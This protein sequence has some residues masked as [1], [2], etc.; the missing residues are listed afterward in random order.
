[1]RILSA[2][3]WLA[4]MSIAGL[5][6]GLSQAIPRTSTESLSAPSIPGAAFGP[7]IDEAVLRL[8][9]DVTRCLGE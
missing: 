8:G 2:L 9:G 5:A 4:V 3:S 1:M 7:S 6:I